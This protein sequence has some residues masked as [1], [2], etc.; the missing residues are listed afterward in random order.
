MDVIFVEEQPVAGV[1]RRVQPGTTV[2]RIR[3][4]VVLPDGSVSRRHAVFHQVGEGIGV[5]DLGSRS[6]TYVNDRLTQGVAPLNKGDVVRFGGTVWRLVT[7]VDADPDRLPSAIRRAVPTT[8]F[9]GELPAFDAVPAPGPV[10]GF[11]AAR[12][13]G[14]TI[15][16]YLVILATVALVT[17]FFVTR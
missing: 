13:L 8:V 10:L 9:Y 14:A 17:L 7:A 1:E 6:G 16:C 15:F 12:V 3:S 2:G 5:E 11:S 4:D